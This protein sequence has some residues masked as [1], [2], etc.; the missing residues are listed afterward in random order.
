MAMLRFALLTWVVLSA[1]AAFAQDDAEVKADLAALQ[2]AW[3][4]TKMQA[5]GEMPPPGFI[6][7]LQLVFTDT[8]VSLKLAQRTE[9]C[10]YKIDPK[11]KP[12][13]LDMT[14]ETNKEL[15]VLGIYELS[16]DVL[17]IC[18]SK[19]GARPTAF[20]ANAGEDRLLLELARVK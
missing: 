9:T 19:K 10:T 5:A 16:G 3:R 14:P 8:T 13:T 4:I 6:E 2:G 7:Q 17:K 20:T 12:K 1:A 18:W 15:N 11:A